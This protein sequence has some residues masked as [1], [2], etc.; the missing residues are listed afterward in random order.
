LWRDRVQDVRVKENYTRKH[1]GK[2]PPIESSHRSSSVRSVLQALK[3][4][5]QVLSIL[6]G[7]PTPSLLR[8]GTGTHLLLAYY[9]AE[10][11]HTSE[12]TIPGLALFPEFHML[13]RL[14]IWAVD[15]ACFERY[16]FQ[17]RC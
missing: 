9:V 8:R 14:D 6:N 2:T 15:P 7:T 13:E 16:G 1:N 11:E 4:G 3:R 17:G 12:P 5:Y 10:P